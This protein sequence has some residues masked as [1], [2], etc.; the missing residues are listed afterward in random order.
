MEGARP[1]CEGGRVPGR[2]RAQRVGED[3]PAAGAARA[4][5]AVGGTVTVNGR[6]P[7]RGSG[8]IGYVPQH[9]AVPPHT[10]CAPVTW[11]GWGWTGTGG[12]AAAV[13]RRAPPGRG[14][15]A[16]RGRRPYADVP[17]HLLSGG[18]LQRVRVAQAWPPI[19]ASCSATSRSRRWTPGIS[20]S[21]E[22]W[23]TDGGASRARRS[24]S[25]PTRSTRCCRSRTGCW[26][27]ARRRELARDRQ[28]RRLRA[29]LALVRNSLIAGPCSGSSAG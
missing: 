4:A 29:L 6:P 16:G 15:T 10:R 7:R 21:S 14:G 2:P 19:R 27:W 3:E 11:W 24:C 13:P 20:G 17:L 26:I 25:S 1:R 8:F 12:A 18:E 9:R 28:L 23:S 5:A 22:S